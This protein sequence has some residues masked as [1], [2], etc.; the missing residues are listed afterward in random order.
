MK[1]A[2]QTCELV[3]GAIY[4]NVTTL[5]SVLSG[6]TYTAIYLARTLHN[7]R[8]TTAQARSH[9]TDKDPGNA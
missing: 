6:N 5:N 7:R 1:H 4:L 8:T 3:N 2:Y 9:F